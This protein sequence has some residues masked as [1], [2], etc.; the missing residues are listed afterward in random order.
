LSY[1]PVKGR[2]KLLQIHSGSQRGIEKN[3][4]KNRAQTRREFRR[5][6]G[7]L[8]HN[9]ICKIFCR[10]GVGLKK[11]IRVTDAKEVGVGNPAEETYRYPNQNPSITWAPGWFLST[12]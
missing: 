2:T 12:E 8:C 7:A 6:K 5:K 10:W 11:R 1:A 4:E 9:N 3:P